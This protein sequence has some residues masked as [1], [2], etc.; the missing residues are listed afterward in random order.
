[1]MIS[2]HHVKLVLSLCP[3]QLNVN[4]LRFVDVMKVVHDPIL[5]KFFEEGVHENEA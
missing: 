3:W 1:M 4:K 5:L 2:N